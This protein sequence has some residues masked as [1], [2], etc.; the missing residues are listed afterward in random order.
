[1]RSAVEDSVQWMSPFLACFCG[2]FRPEPASVLCWF[3]R[4]GLAGNKVGM[5]GIAPL[6][7]MLC[8]CEASK[9]E[10]LEQKYRR[11]VEIYG[12]RRSCADEHLIAEAWA[13]EGNQRRYEQ[14]RARE[15]LQCMRE[16]ARVHELYP[17]AGSDI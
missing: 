1:M 3:N 4:T 13:R 16:Q 8:G 5:K 7:L 15:K 2:M 11:S 6:C 9:A 10:L 17:G 14:A 12:Q